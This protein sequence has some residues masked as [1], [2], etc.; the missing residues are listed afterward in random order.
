MLISILFLFLFLFLAVHMET[1]IVFCQSSVTCKILRT[2]NVL[3]LA[4]ALFFEEGASD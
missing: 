3:M 2:E 1:L 4:Q